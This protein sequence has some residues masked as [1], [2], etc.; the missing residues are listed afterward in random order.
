MTDLKFFSALMDESFLRFWDMSWL[1]GAFRQQG[2]LV[3][4]PT[5]MLHSLVARQS[6]VG[7]VLVLYTS[8]E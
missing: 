2:F 4:T 6:T 3:R 1:S 5:R 7:D 8:R